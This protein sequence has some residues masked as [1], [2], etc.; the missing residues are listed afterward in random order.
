MDMKIDLRKMGRVGAPEFF[1]RRVL[2][3]LSQRREKR[4]RIRRLRLSLA[5]AGGA[6]ALVLVLANLFVVPG[7]SP[8]DLSGLEKKLAA[9]SI[10]ERY[11][12]AGTVI[13][14]TETVNYSREIRSRAGEP[15][16]VYILEQ[17]SNTSDARII[18]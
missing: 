15:P 6:F 18:Y 16:T 13:P 4:S 8:V 2:T 10:Q 11:P 5:G 9:D 17:V 1:E 3:E 7:Q 14:V 12:A